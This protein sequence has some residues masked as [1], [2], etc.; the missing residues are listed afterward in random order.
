MKKNKFAIV[1]NFA[2][3]VLIFSALIF[4]GGKEF[5]KFHVDFRVATLVVVVLNSYVMIFSKEAVITK[6]TMG[7][8]ALCGIV[9]AATYLPWFQH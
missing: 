6:N 3:I 8:L 1:A 5:G 7:A 4:I 9:Y 2:A